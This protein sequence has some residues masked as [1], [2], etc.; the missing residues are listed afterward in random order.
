MM[1][2]PH[3]GILVERF[4]EPCNRDKVLNEASE[5]TSLAV[6]PETT[7]D[8]KNIAFGV[9]SPLEGFLNEN[10][11]L[12]VL[13]HSRLPSDVPWTIPIILDIDEEFK[14][15]V[16]T[17]DPIALTSGDGVI[18]ATMDIEDIFNYDKKQYAQRVFQTTDVNHPGV[19]KVMNRKK[20]LVGGKIDLVTEINGD[21]SKYNLKPKETRVLFHKKG[22]KS[23][24]AF[25]TRNPPHLGHEY[26]QKAS[27]NVVDGLLINPVIGK[28]KPGDFLDKIIIA[29][30]ETLIKNYYV[31]DSC[32]L[33]TF[34]TEMHYAGPKEAIHH[35]IARKNLGCTHFIVGRDHAGVGDYYRPF[36]AH[37][38]FAEFP[39]LGIE[40]ICFRSFFKC[41]KCNSVVSDR[42]CP[43]GEEYQ[44]NFKG[45]V[46]R[47]MLSEGKIPTEEMRPEVAE[48]IIKFGDLF[49]K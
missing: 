43:H 38:I 24:V 8:L 22:W 36:D 40:P 12:S 7:K 42:V 33:S 26:V 14:A 45:R 41:T 3:G 1:I 16:K 23:V 11:F 39:D 2:E 13:D 34:E 4:V 31:K 25:Q 37:K 10:E 27:L 49:V 5:F 48:T 17:G 9:L 35:S 29:A 44:V 20:F 47:K 28:K 18:L 30:Y 19:A 15:G 46:V 21:L 32:V 6:N